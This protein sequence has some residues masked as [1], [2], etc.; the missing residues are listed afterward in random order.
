[1]SHRA[2]DAPAIASAATGALVRINVREPQV[3]DPR[4]VGIS[5]PA[6]EVL[7]ALDARTSEP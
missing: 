1:M 2:I 3:R 4:G 5:A 6:A 7:L